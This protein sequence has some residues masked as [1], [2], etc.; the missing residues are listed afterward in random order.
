[1]AI[2]NINYLKEISS[3]RIQETNIGIKRYLYKK[4]DWRDR[5]IMIKGMRGVGKT[6]LMLQHLK[7]NFGIS[8]KAIYVSLD[9]LWFADNSLRDV[10]EYHYLHG[11]T[12]IYIDEVHYYKNWQQLIKNL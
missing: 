8:D 5:L 11:G 10:A 12:H 9:N 6:T 7:E 1:M 4:I 3:R 2:D